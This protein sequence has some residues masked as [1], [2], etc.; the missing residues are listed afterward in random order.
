MIIQLDPQTELLA[1]KSQLDR[2]IVEGLERADD[3]LR[4]LGGGCEDEQFYLRTSAF[5]QTLCRL[6]TALAGRAAFCVEAARRYNAC[7]DA[8]MAE[9]PC[10]SPLDTGRW[11]VEYL[12][13][14]YQVRRYLPELVDQ[15]VA[16]RDAALPRLAE[17]LNPPAA[18][19]P[20]AVMGVVRL[21]VRG[22]LRA[23]C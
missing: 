3:P 2:L 6:M 13:L 21:V 19:R 5:Y 9:G 16:L 10:T 7:R 23:A 12:T 8:V 14:D 18:E 4:R 15:L 22:E 1:L 17:A 11:E 20:E